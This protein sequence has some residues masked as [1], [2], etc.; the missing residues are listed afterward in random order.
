VSV[1]LQKRVEVAIVEAISKTLP[2]APQYKIREALSREPYPNDTKYQA[3]IQKL[4][5]YH[6]VAS[7]S[8]YRRL[9]RFM[10]Q[11]KQTVN[12]SEQSTHRTCNITL[13]EEQKS[14]A[15]FMT[16]RITQATFTPTLLH[17]VTGSG[18]TEVYKKCIEHAIDYNKSAILLLPEVTLAV[19]FSQLLRAAY[20]SRIPIYDFHS[21]ASASEK[22]ALWQAITTH[23]PSLIIGV[24]LPIL[25]PIKNLGCIIVDEEHDLGYQEKKHPKMNTKELALLRAH[26]YDIPILLGSATPSMTSLYQAKQDNWHFFQLKKRFS[27][28]FPKIKI[29][30]LPQQEK[31]SHFWISRELEH[32]I[33]DRLKKREQTIIFINRRGYS[34]FIRCGECGFICTC[35]SCSVSLTL[36]ASGMLKCH[37]CNFTQEQPAT[38]PSCNA[39]AQ[40]FIKKGL[41]TQQ[42]VQI[43]EK[44]MPHARIGRADLDTTVNKKQWQETIQAFHN[45]DI[46]ILV[47][48]QTITKGY[49]FPHV[50]LVGILWADINLALPFY[51]ASERTLQQLI[52]V[53]GRA[54]RHHTESLVIAQTML[55]H[56]L[57]Q[58]IN[59]TS[60]PA[61][62]DYEIQHREELDYPPHYRIAEIEV[63]HKDE[64]TAERDAHAIRKRIKQ[65]C[66]KEGL[67]LR[68]LGPA[69]P[70]VHK[71]KNIFS[72]KLYIKSPSYAHIHRAYNEIDMSDIQSNIYY[73]PNPVQ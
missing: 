21:A 60:Y 11:K 5:A 66:S 20:G 59:E 8:V 53:A 4:S 68:T 71:I 37:Y 18:K 26:T 44:M 67:T 32:A 36:H 42:V 2:D 43:L 6:N 48:T 63:R 33:R 58:Y 15:D 22:K 7:G 35:K 23:Q 47:G 54:G 49:H 1:P 40:K 69:Q 45:R 56:P 9:Q 62:Y 16:D 28:A 39:S 70:V 72:Q 14:V 57:Y 31:R 19:Q 10:T 65:I 3:Y 50:T 73:T 46:D 52:Q 41:G 64:K 38:C 51:N 29:A 61:F 27:G 17:G 55:D 34:F 25:L 12:T 13:T 24:H 30:H